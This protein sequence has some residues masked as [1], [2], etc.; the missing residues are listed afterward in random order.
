MLNFVHYLTKWQAGK[1]EVIRLCKRINR[2]VKF[3][4]KNS[5]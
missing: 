2:Y 4:A 1:C 3:G 5:V